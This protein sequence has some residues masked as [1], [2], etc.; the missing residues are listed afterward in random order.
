MV[1]LAISFPGLLSVSG[2]AAI[3]KIAAGWSADAELQHRLRM[4]PRMRTDHSELPQQVVCW[5]GFDFCE[6]SKLKAVPQRP[7]I[8]QR[9]WRLGAR[10]RSPGHP[11]S[12]WQE[13]RDSS[14]ISPRRNPQSGADVD[15]WEQGAPAFEEQMILK[16]KSVSID[17]ECKSQPHVGF[18]FSNSLSTNM[19]DKEQS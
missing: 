15:L 2:P 7:H 9:T 13:V 10:I 3:G 16:L 11:D 19:I 17:D 8:G 12:A 5:T 4:W 1:L 14:Q 6:N 18:L